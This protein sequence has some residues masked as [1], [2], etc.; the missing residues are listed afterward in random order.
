MKKSMRVPKKILE[1]RAEREREREGVVVKHIFAVKGQ[2]KYYEG[3][4]Q[5][6]DPT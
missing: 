4:G 6:Y 2:V 3:I 5:T 1:S